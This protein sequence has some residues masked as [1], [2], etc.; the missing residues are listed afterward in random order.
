MAISK[1]LIALLLALLIA[2]FSLMLVSAGAGGLV[3]PIGPE[4]AAPCTQ[5]YA[6]ILP[7][8]DVALL[9]QV[10]AVLAQI[11]RADA[12]DCYG[13]YINPDERPMWM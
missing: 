9:E 11:R 12:G 2:S 7:Q 13:L 5:N 1:T 4:P 6:A 8:L 3:E 10:N